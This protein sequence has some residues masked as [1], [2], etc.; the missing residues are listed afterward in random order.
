M[1]DHTITYNFSDETFDTWCTKVY[2][3]KDLMLEISN[4]DI[5][6]APSIG[7]RREG[8]ATFP[9]GTE[10]IFRYLQQH[11]PN[12]KVEIC[13]AD[14]QYSEL[15][16]YSNS[17]EIGIFV[18]KNVLLPTFVGVLSTYLAQVM[19]TEKDKDKNTTVINVYNGKEDRKEESQVNVE[20]IT[21]KAEKESHKHL[22]PPHVKFTVYIVDSASKKS[23]K[24]DYD[25]PANQVKTVTKEFKT[26]WE[27]E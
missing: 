1:S 6:L 11:M 2:L 16:L 14:D 26:A 27:N 23:I 12:N 10:S 15:G 4:A 8:E 13:I 21:A 3:P 22:Q 24:L 18:V 19:F 7:F 5:L 25:G 9:V 20:Q 17:K